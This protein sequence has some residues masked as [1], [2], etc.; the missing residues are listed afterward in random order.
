MEFFRW[1][2]MDQ[3]SEKSWI[4]TRFEWNWCQLKAK[5]PFHCL[6]YKSW[7]HTS[8]SWNRKTATRGIE[9]IFLIYYEATDRTRTAF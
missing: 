6:I 9:Y 7:Y 2:G 1:W 3:L 8:C 4:S 5:S